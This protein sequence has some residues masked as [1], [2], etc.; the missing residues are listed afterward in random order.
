MLIYVL[1][2]EGEIVEWLGDMLMEYATCLRFIERDWN[3]IE[4]QM[5]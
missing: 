3:R 5:Q 1:L 4:I 2:F